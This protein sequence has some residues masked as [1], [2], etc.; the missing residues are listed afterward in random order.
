[1]GSVRRDKEH[2]PQPVNMSTAPSQRIDDRR[3]YMTWMTLS[4]LR[5]TR[6]DRFK[7]DWLVSTSQYLVQ[8]H[9]T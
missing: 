1:M 6:R 4:A 8:C 3:A 9:G 5:Q 2:V 7:S